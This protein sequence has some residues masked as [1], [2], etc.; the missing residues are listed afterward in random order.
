M[1][2]L[3]VLRILQVGL[4]VWDLGDLGVPQTPPPQPNMV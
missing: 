3:P 4:A 1:C 2:P